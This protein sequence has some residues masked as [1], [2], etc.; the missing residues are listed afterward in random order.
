M[1]LFTKGDI[2]MLKESEV[3]ELKKSK[4][5]LSKGIISITAMLNK[6]GKGELYFGVKDD[7]IVVG[8]DIGK[9]TLREIGEAIQNSIKPQICPTIKGID[10]DGID[11]IHILVEGKEIPYSAFGKYYV[12]VA[13]SDVEMSPDT[14]RTY[15][16]SAD[17]IRQRLTH[18][19]I[20]IKQEI[21]ILF[22]GDNFQKTFNMD[23]II[24]H[25]VV[26]C[27]SDVRRALTELH[28][29]EKIKCN[30]FIE[31]NFGE[32]QFYKTFAKARIMQNPLRL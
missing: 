5:Q 17:A 4:G 3:L 6:H 8:H 9:D 19:F 12:R 15:M 23:D 20:K 16:I 32:N 24:T 29:E 26:Y 13:D 28:K 25:F 11:C 18:D 7:G 22:G 30:K 2:K 14:L 1:L 31:E 10:I 21:L 27:E